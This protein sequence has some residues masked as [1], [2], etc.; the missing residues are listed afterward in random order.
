[1][2][3][4]T[5]TTNY[6]INVDQI[7]RRALRICGALGQ[8]ETPTTAQFNESLQALN[9]IAKEWES[10][11][12]QLWKVQ[13]QNF[14]LVASQ[15]AYQFYTGAVPPQVNCPAFLKLLHVRLTTISDGSD[16]PL[17]PIT[18]NQYDFLSNKTEGGTPNQYWY[19]PPGNMNTGQQVGIITFFNTPDTSAA[20]TYTCTVT[21]LQPLQDFASATDLADFPSF[22]NNALTWG[23]ADQLAYENPTPVSEQDRITKKAMYHKQIALNFDVEEGS[24]WFQPDPF[25]LWESYNHNFNR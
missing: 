4:T 15:A 12:M 2:A 17:V 16:I 8:G 3:T 18:R 5:G 19:N 20:S 21:G 23:L 6:T 14:S 9:D 11:G 1:M 25:W 13:D 22:Y 10:D 7:I 24:V